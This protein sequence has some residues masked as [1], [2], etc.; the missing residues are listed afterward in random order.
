M[1]KI[2][3]NSFKELSQIRNSTQ[4]MNDAKNQPHINQLLGYIWQTNE[5][6]VLFADTG[7]GKSIIAVA[8]IDSLTKGKNFL[9]LENENLPLRALYYDFELS[10]R[11][12][13]KRYTNDDGQEHDFNDTFYIDTIDFA[14]LIN[15]YPKAEFVDLLFERFRYDIETIGANILVID[16]LTFLS[17]Q[18][19]QDTQVALEVMR[20][21]NELKKEF[22]LSIL[23]L[24][25][26]PKRYINSPITIVDLAGSKHLSSFAD[27][28]SA[29]GKSTQGKNIRYWKQV[30]PSRSG[31]LIFD[32]GNV[33]V[34][35]IDKPDNFLTMKHIGFSSEWDHLKEETGNEET[36]PQVYEVIE[37]LKQ[38]QSYGDIA[39]KLG[40]SKGTITKWK[41]RFPQLFV[42]V[43]AVSE[44]GSLGNKE[45]E[46]IKPTSNNMTIHQ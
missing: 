42:S 46:T 7:I 41:N 15:M 25:H 10:D 39:K 45:T 4:R 21:L 3:K 1:D 16:N 17:T 38:H 28:V 24:A 26:T 9:F 34:L 35:E 2:N 23:V 12:F 27:S 8:T 18:S 20:K 13:N 36:P 22:N 19:T 40:I 30:K 6:H 5:L 14:E 44:S 32:T 33:I 29:I 43:S 31:E 37:L 11:Q